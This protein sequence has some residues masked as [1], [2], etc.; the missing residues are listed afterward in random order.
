MSTP[1]LVNKMV[2]CVSP[3]LF[4]AT[5]CM[6]QARAEAETSGYFSNPLFLLLLVTIILL[7]AFIAVLGN[8]LQNIAKS[9][10][11]AEKIKKM[12][13]KAASSKQ[14]GIILLFILFNHAAFSQ[15]ALTNKEPWQIGGLDYF[16]FWSMTA[17]ILCEI[18]VIAV[19]FIVMKN[20][21]K[22]ER[23]EISVTEVPK[24]KE[25]SLMDK[26][27]ASIEIENEE[28]I[29][30]THNYDGIKELDNNLPPW[31]KYG[32]YITIVAACVYMIHYHVS[33]T[34]DLQE[35]E[36][37]KEISRA[38]EEVAEFLKRSANNVDETNVKMLAAAPDL[39]AGK[40]LF[41]S[42]CATC[43]GKMGEGNA[44]GPNLTD[45]YWLH[46]GSIQGVFKSIKY[47]WTDKGM[48][49]W[50][51]SY[52]PMQIAQLASYIRSLRG[53]NP[54]NAKEKQGELYIEKAPA[55]TSGGADSL[56]IVLPPDTAGQ[57][58][59]EKK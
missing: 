51:D 49:A 22:E 18:A 25:K 35:T 34:G 16:T 13:D 44:I 11:L 4:L 12:S 52:S 24:P 50:K 30:L 2:K 31:W 7:L 8:T 29:M 6:A 19:L 41:T 58:L 27:N 20:L 23:K 26:L 9:D 33:K 54:A 42:I 46:G 21:L 56:K 55:D 28:E 48:Q 45:D 3:I 32:F 40:Y 10:Y 53:S 17:L 57:E 39:A 15:N 43:H 59:V 47:G 36:Y 38:E 14:G 5:P 37:K 1:G